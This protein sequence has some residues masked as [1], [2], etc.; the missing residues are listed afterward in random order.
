MVYRTD[1]YILYD[2]YH[3]KIRKEYRSDFCYKILYKWIDIRSKKVKV[4]IFIRAGK[5]KNSL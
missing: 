4:N 5:S 1:F 3:F 2:K